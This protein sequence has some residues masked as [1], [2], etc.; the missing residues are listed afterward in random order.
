MGS[1]E[2]VVRSVNLC[3]LDRTFLGILMVVRVDMEG[4]TSG[5]IRVLPHGET[6][7]GAH[8]QT[9]GEDPH[10]HD[11]SSVNIVCFLQ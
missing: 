5:P 10:N 3:G 7:R 11:F 9:R 4:V 8:G 2:G 1:Q 6:R